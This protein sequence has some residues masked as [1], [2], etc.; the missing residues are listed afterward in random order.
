M[1]ENWCLYVY[2]CNSQAKT[3]IWWKLAILD[4]KWS[5]TSKMS[6]V[7]WNPEDTPYLTQQIRRN[8]ILRWIRRPLPDF[9]EYAA[10]HSDMRRIWNS[11]QRRRS[12]L[13][14]SRY[15]AFTIEERRISTKISPNVDSKITIYA[16]HQRSRYAAF[17]GRCTNILEYINLGPHAKLSQCAASIT[18]MRRIDLPDRNYINPRPTRI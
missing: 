1:Y 7:Y 4:Q 18:Y 5:K 6:K 8:I 2:F 3:G 15:A 12:S 11:G 9:E 10:C 13:F 16:P 14:Y 17:A